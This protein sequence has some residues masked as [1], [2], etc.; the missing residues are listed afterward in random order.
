MALRLLLEGR[1]T[2]VSLKNRPLIS[3]LLAVG[4][5]M[6]HHRL[7]MLTVMNFT[8]SLAS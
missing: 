6:D 8:M 3:G 4:L 7:G 1:P 5:T 2:K